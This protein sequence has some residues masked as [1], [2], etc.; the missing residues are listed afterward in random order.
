MD[1][2]WVKQYSVGAPI[3]HRLELF[4]EYLV[5]DKRV[6][7]SY[8]VQSSKAFNYRYEAGQEQIDF[9]VA[10]KRYNNEEYFP[11][12][13]DPFT[14]PLCPNGLTDCSEAYNDKEWPAARCLKLVA[15]LGE[16]YEELVSEL[17]RLNHKNM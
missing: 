11:E 15:R 3:S 1:R 6:V 13:P 14:H 10:C 8:Y 9:Y 16:R 5:I 17:Q 7:N 12:V 2:S 4:L